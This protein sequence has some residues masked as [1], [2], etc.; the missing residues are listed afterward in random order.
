MRWAAAR[1][2]MRIKNIVESE[3]KKKEDIYV[4]ERMSGGL[5]CW[6]QIM[7]NRQIHH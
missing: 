2:E 5:A 1:S 3:W 6:T 4:C 7:N